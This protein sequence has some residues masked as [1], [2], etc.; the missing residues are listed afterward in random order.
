MNF[1]ELCQRTASECSASLTGPDSTVSQT[2]RL[3]QIVKW[4]NAAWMDIQTRHDNWL[5]MRGSFSV[6]TTSGDGV[7][8]YTDCT[9]V[10]TSATIT[11]FRA[12]DREK[13]KIYLTSAG[14][15]SETYLIPISYDLW[16]SRFNTGSQ[17]NSFPRYVAVDNARRFLLGA[18]PDGI[19]T[20]R[21]EYIKAATELSGNSDTPGMPSEY[22]MAIVYRAMMKYGRYTG[23]AEVF[24]DGQAEYTRMMKE[25]SR[26]T[27]T[28]D[29]KAEPLA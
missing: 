16:Y 22:H 25:A 26:N 28:K 20:V 17:T 23:A 8:A 29:K 12:W 11:A 2:G 6:S 4:V 13:F 15:N 21:G 3:G 24:N 10:D 9:D 5:W 19:Y 18:K 27:R 14:A 1:L 7:Y